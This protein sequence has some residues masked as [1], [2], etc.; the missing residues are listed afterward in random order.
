MLALL[1]PL[2]IFAGCS[3][4][5]DLASK[6]SGSYSITGIVY[7]TDG[8][9]PLSGV[10]VCAGSDS[11]SDT[12]DSN[13]KYT[14]NGISKGTVQLKAKKDGLVFIASFAVSGE[15][16]TGS[17]INVSQAATN[18][19]VQNANFYARYSDNIRIA[20]I[21]GD[22][23][24]SPLADEEVVGI[25]GVVTMVCYKTPDW[26]YDNETIDGSSIAQYGSEDGF[27]IE[28]LP[29]DKDLSGNKSNG[30]FIYTHDDTYT[31]S[32]WKSGIPTDITPGQ[33]VTVSG[34]VQERRKLDR[35]NASE[36]TL[37]RTVI[38]ASS[39]VQNMEGS[40]YVTTRYPDGVLITYSQ[41]IA[42]SWMAGHESDGLREY[43]LMPYD[44]VGLESGES[45]IKA[46]E[47]AINVLESVEGMVVRIDNPL[48]V[49]GTYYGLTGILAD[50]GYEY[51]TDAANGTRFETFNESW[52]GNVLQ[53][54]DYNAEILFVDYVTPTR[55]SGSKLTQIGDH[56]IDSAGKAVLRGVMDYTDDGLYII[57]TLQNY[58]IAANYP[59]DMTY[60]GSTDARSVTGSIIPEQGWDF[61][62][63]AVW[64]AGNST[65]KT[66]MENV[67][68]STIREWRTGSATKRADSL[69]TPEWEPYSDTA[70]GNTETDTLTFSSF[71][72]ENYC[73]QGS[74]KSKLTNLGYIIRN[75]LLYPDIMV[76]VEMGDDNT[77]EQTYSNLDGSYALKDGVVSAVVNCSTII[78][79]IHNNGGPTYEF[80]QIDPKEQDSGGSAGVNI[81]L[82]MLYNTERVEFVDTG[83]PSN[84]YANTH[85]INELTG[86]YAFDESDLLDSSDW[87]VQT[88]GLSGD[89]LA[90]TNATAVL[91][92]D[93]KVHLVQS[94]AYIQDASYEVSRHPLV[95]EFIFKP[96][97]ETVFVVACHLGSMR[98][99]YSLYGE[100]QPPLMLSEFKRTKQ[101]KSVYNFVNQILKYDSNAKIIVAGDMNAFA[102]TDPL[103]FLTGEM[104]G[105]QILYSPAE[106]YLPV[107]ERFSYY[108]QGNLQQIDHIYVSKDILTKMQNSGLST[109]N[110][111]PYIFVPHINSVVSRNNSLN[112]SEHDP[113]MLRLYK[114][115][116]Q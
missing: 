37:T 78:D 28:A 52:G 58:T 49:G 29:A 102:Y 63:D 55:K 67:T 18:G 44:R 12:T 51:N 85:K 2:S 96:T 95:G 64:Y 106:M 90:D 73:N 92:S 13:G 4:F 11:K 75:N 114:V 70:K 16:V 21:Q 79:T 46:L 105:N 48:V 43:R 3:V 107:N 88:P 42:D 101:A 80:R 36:A 23:L 24:T 74:S 81:R 27:Y 54:D 50:N 94:P 17:S 111:T 97:N 9:T 30:I 93:G 6:S 109:T 40:N 108:F 22:N 66:A 77:T 47:L 19:T 103:R 61:N 87:P 41:S 57:Q 86:T 25:T 68:S 34:T 56:I 104:Q 84:T 31:E 69:F 38:N 14:I 115:M 32:K 35:Y 26:Y 116:G 76:F 8:T 83:L 113:D 82:V 98:G 45:T 60:F 91:G 59:V 20:D 99:D 1:L 71:N 10:E 110:Y 5:N 53:E 65:I 33:V 100:V 89:I 72:L 39:V 62:S 15:Y 112:F 7:G